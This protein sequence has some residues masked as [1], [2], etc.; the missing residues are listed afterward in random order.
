VV[1]DAASATPEAEARSLFEF[2]CGLR[3]LRCTTVA[4]AGPVAA[5]VDDLP[6]AAD[7]VAPIESRQWTR[8]V[9]GVAGS[10]PPR[11]C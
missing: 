2:S 7:R 8:S 5:L 4:P 11:P 3:E 10:W 6:R 9:S 1:D